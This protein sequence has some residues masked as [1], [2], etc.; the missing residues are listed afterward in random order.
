MFTNLTV[1]FNSGEDWAS[2]C[3]FVTRLFLPRKTLFLFQQINSIGEKT[4]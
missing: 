1:N 4:F 3:V 2:A